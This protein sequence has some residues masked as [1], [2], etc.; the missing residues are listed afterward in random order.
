M[1]ETLIGVYWPARACDLNACARLAHTH[2]EA[3]SHF[4]KGLASWFKLASRKPKVPVAA[5]VG[6]LDALTGLLRKGVSRTDT[7]RSVI[8]ELGWSIRF[9]NG[10]V[11]GCT[12]NTSIKCGCTSPWVSNAAYVSI[13]REGSVGMDDAKAL[14]LMEALVGIWNPESGVVQQSRWNAET[15][16]HETTEVATFKRER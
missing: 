15:Q 14:K 2:F 12:A 5:D 13:S 3:I 8:E 6:S 1:P 10:E 9:W 7:D 4:D 16:A 11:G